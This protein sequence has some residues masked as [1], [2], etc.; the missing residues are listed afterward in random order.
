MFSKSLKPTPNF[1]QQE[2]R[3]K[4]E[5]FELSIIEILNQNLIP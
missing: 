2:V 5:D 3:N 4:L 1:T